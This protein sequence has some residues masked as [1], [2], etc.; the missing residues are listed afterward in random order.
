MAYLAPLLF[1]ALLI[2]TGYLLNAR[3]NNPLPRVGLSPGPWSMMLWP[4]RIYF[5]VY[6]YEM[7]Q[8]AYKQV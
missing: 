4:A 5:A 7:V 1:F 8:E 3:R 2:I 6:G